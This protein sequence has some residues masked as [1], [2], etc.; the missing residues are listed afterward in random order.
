[1]FVSS[2][3]RQ[4]NPYKL[5]KL[6]HKTFAQ[7]GENHHIAAWRCYAGLVTQVAEPLCHAL[8]GRDRFKEIE[9]QGMNNIAYVLDSETTLFRAVELQIGISFSPIYD[10]VGSPLI[11]MIRFDDMH[12]LFL[13]EEA[14][15]DGLTAFTRFDGCLKPLAG[16]IVLVGG[17]G[18][19][20]YHSPL[21]S[22][23][24][25]AARFQ[26]CRPVLDPVFVEPDDVMSK[27]L[28]FPGAL[29]GLQFRIDSCPPMLVA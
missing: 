28:I 24:D 20:P 4:L 29:K 26:C 27:G 5:I 12:S 6:A 15:R 16:K 3:I 19:E 13:D 23:A 17:D 10:L 21:I 8:E 7:P 9:G 25:A 14:L 1:M 2:D 18:R 11:E 22:I